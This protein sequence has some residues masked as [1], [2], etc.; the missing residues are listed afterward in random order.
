MQIKKEYR[1]A[2]DQI[3]QIITPMGACIAS[4]QITVEGK[5]VR[6]MYREEPETEFDSGW[7]FFS[8][9]ESQDYIDDPDNMAFFD[10]N[11][12]VNYDKAI[13]PYLNLPEGTELERVDGSSEFKVIEG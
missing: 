4:D 7:R 11:T 1:L 5:L 9:N 10:V 8:G 2:E 3:M 13:I 6:Y 12:I